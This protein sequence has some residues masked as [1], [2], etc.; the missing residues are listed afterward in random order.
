VKETVR[1]LLNDGAYLAIGEIELLR[2]NTLSETE[3]P[4]DN[5]ICILREG[6]DPHDYIIGR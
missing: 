6:V 4:C 5:E 3:P 2:E 1:E